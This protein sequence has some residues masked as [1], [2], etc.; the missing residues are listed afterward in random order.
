M[1]MIKLGIRGAVILGEKS[2]MDLLMKIV[3][4]FRH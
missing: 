1:N 3:D 2:K 4:G